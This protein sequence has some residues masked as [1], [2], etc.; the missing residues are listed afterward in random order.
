[1]QI[2]TLIKSLNLT[3]GQIGLYTGIGLFSGLGFNRGC[4]EY[5]LTKSNEKK[6]Y[7]IADY[8]NSFV[9]GIIGA[10]IYLNPAFTGFAIYHEYL[11]AKMYL[12]K[13]KYENKNIAESN[14]FFNLH[15]KIE[16]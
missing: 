5:S 13:D 10:S 1:M 6:E 16:N 3:K 9:F 11:R 2:N 12:S 14:L 7:D 8:L 15:K 4:Q